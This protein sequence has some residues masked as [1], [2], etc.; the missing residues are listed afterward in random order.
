[1]KHR[2]GGHR[3]RIRRTSVENKPHR[4]KQHQRPEGGKKSVTTLT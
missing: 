3:D 1:M 2:I 4:K